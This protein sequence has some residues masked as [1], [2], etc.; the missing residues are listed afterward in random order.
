MRQVEYTEPALLQVADVIK[1]VTLPRSDQLLVWHLCQDQK[2]RPW[3]SFCTPA[4]R[5]RQYTGTSVHC[6]RVARFHS[7]EYRSS[8]RQS[9]IAPGLQ[10]WRLQEGLISFELQVE[11]HSGPRQVSRAGSLKGEL[12]V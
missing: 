7:L 1:Y 3:S 9:R 2:G 4:L 10:M 12:P 6:V 8:R 11:C 5:Q